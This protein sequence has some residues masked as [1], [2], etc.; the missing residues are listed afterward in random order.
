MILSLRKSLFIFPVK[1]PSIQR[2]L[3]LS[4]L[5]VPPRITEAQVTS[6]GMAIQVPSM[7]TGS[8]SSDL[9]RRREDSSL[10]TLKIANRIRCWVGLA[11]KTSLSPGLVNIEVQLASQIPRG[12]SVF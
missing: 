7:R 5:F 9:E 3:H 1:S 2:G 8:C 4:I 12:G 10:I 11:A 6:R